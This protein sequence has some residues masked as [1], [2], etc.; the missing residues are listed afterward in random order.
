MS[1]SQKSNSRIEEADLYSCVPLTGRIAGV[2]GR[3]IETAVFRNL[4]T[5]LT[6]QEGTRGEPSSATGVRSATWVCLQSEHENMAREHR[7]QH[8]RAIVEPPVRYRLVVATYPKD[9][10]IRAIAFSDGNDVAW[11]LQKAVLQRAFTFTEDWRAKYC[12]DEERERGGRLITRIIDAL[13]RRPQ[14]I[15]LDGLRAECYEQT[16]DRMILHA[17]RAGVMWGVLSASPEHADFLRLCRTAYGADSWRNSELES[18]AFR[19]TGAG[20][21]WH[22]S[23]D[24]AQA[25]REQNRERIRMGTQRA[26]RVTVHGG[27]SGNMVV[28]DN[29]GPQTSNTYNAAPNDGV[30]E[31]LKI[32]LSRSEIP[33]SS[34]LA[35][36]RPVVEDAVR[37]GR[38]D[39]AELRPAVARILAVCSDLGLAVA[40][41]TLFE[42]LRAFVM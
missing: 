39:S 9:G 15:T 29:Y 37:Q 11:H 1:A 10:S 22:Q 14:G 2:T 38:V 31:A 25:A 16:P 26:P 3:M 24:E 27:I 34:E 5:S 18:M 19:L 12:S 21:C 41:S 40:G 28:G 8:G 7:R 4:Q 35:S 36:V 13:N 32:A 6:L 30:L 42:V 23:S 17:V 20:R 33:W